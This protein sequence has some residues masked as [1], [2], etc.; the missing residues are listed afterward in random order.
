MEQYI[1]IV[2]EGMLWEKCFIDFDGVSYRTSGADGFNPFIMPR[3]LTR[4]RGSEKKV[5]ARDTGATPSSREC[6]DD[7]GWNAR[8]VW[9]GDASWA[10]TGS[11]C[12]KLGKVATDFHERLTR[13]AKELFAP[14]R[15]LKSPAARS[16]AS[17]WA[18]SYAISIQTCWI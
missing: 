18:R 2:W 5:Q 4:G 13:S 3:M 12:A 16:T 11:I 1:G 17:G 8:E 14:A 6:G 15:Y 7:W 9:Y 10:H